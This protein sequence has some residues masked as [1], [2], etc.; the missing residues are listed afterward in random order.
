MMSTSPSW[1]IVGF[2][3]KRGG[4]PSGIL[5][6]STRQKNAEFARIKRTQNVKFL[7]HQ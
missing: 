5:R 1:R 3:G 2:F 6:K 7:L 4:L